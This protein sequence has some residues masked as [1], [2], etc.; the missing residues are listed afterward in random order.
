MK[1][2]TVTRLIKSQQR[3]PLKRSYGWAEDIKT[4]LNH[5]IDTVAQTSV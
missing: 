2:Q 3:S 4:S 5:D 1:P